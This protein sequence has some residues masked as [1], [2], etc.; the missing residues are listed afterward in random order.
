M[1]K[2]MKEEKVKLNDEQ[3]QK[4]KKGIGNFK[5]MDKEINELIKK[6]K[7]HKSRRINYNQ[8]VK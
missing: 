1:L 7:E 6:I 5:K 8:K 4:L 2:I 3:K